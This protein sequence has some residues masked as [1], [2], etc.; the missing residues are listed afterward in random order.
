MRKPY[1]ITRR[2]A[3]RAILKTLFRMVPDL[4]DG[5]ESPSDSSRPAG[6]GRAVLR[7]LLSSGDPPA[8]PEAA[9]APTG[10]GLTARE[11]QICQAIRRGR[12]SKEIATDLLISRH[13]VDVHRNNIRRKLGLKGGNGHLANYLFSRWPDLADSEEG[14]SG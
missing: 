5:P 6:D 14:P 8:P 12:S 9:G 1:A 3:V 11:R 7:A 4:R 2:R 10:E 13:T